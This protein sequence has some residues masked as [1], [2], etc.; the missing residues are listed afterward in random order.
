MIRIIIAATSAFVLAACSTVTVPDQKG[1]ITY[2][3]SDLEL[4]ATV[5]NDVCVDNIGDPLAMTKKV[6]QLGAYDAKRER[7]RLDGEIVSIKHYRI[8]NDGR[9][10]VAVTFYGD[11]GACGASYAAGSIPNELLYRETGI[12]MFPGSYN[13]T[14]AGYVETPRLGVAHAQIIRGNSDFDMLMVMNTEMW[15][16]H[17]KATG[18]P[19]LEWGG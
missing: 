11:G 4:V 12:L 14:K 17:R 15:K 18:A 6:N 2:S 13:R 3:Q 5:I 9:Y 7:I 19:E 1:P 8:D 16:S 10:A